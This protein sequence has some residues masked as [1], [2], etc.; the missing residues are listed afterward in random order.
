VKR[1]LSVCGA[2]VILT[3]RR[4]AVWMAGFST[5]VLG[6][7][8]WAARVKHVSGELPGVGVTLV[9]LGFAGCIWVIARS[10]EKLA[11]AALLLVMVQ[12]LLGGLT[13]LYKLP[14]LVL[15]MHL[16]TSMLF[17]ALLEMIKSGRLWAEQERAFGDIVLVEA[18][19][20]PA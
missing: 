18:A 7:A 15:V 11:P 12:G 19:K 9:A 16:G 2:L 4:A 3:M 6:G 17:M 10:S 13:V 5:L 20:T 1:G 14:T 8:I